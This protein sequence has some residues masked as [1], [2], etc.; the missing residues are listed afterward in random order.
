MS[1]LGTGSVTNVSTVNDRINA[2][3]LAPLNKGIYELHCTSN[4]DI[5]THSMP[6]IWEL[7]AKWHWTGFWHITAVFCC[8][9]HL[10][11]PE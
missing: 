8:E 9:H 11:C 6:P 10:S 7:F 2:D 3:F 4:C 5:G 1:H